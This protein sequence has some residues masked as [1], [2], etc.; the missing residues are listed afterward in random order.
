MTNGQP[1]S[2]RKLALAYWYVTNKLLLKNILIAIL[3]IFNVLFIAY[4]IYLLIFNLVIFQKDY[5]TI[6]NNLLAIN[7][8]YQNLRVANL[9]Q[10]IRVGQINIYPNNERYD[11]VAEISNSDPQWWAS[12]DY[13][14]QVSEDLTEKRNSFILPGETKKIVDLSVDNGDLASRLVLTN[15][16]WQKEINYADLK[17]LRLKFDI[18]NVEYIPA[19]ELGVGQELV[20]S[21]VIF[22]IYNNTAFNYK[23]V[24]ILI[25]LKSGDAIVGVNQ[26]GSGALKSGQTNNLESTFFQPLPRITSVEILPEVNILDENVYLSF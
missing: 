23:N 18:Q 17:K 3:I 13:Q 5:Q 2:E 9:P 11:I 26:I 14:F 7:P 12:F 24:S 21:R 25:L 22:S 16:N 20:I 4:L 19:K 8:D 6:L 10:E 1:I 15:V